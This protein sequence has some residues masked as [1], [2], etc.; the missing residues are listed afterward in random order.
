MNKNVLP[1]SQTIRETGYPATG[2]VIDMTF[3]ATTF[4]GSIFR[5]NGAPKMFSFPVCETDPTLEEA[6]H[7]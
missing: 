7:S 4:I 5:M 3:P 2:Q 1:L 6:T